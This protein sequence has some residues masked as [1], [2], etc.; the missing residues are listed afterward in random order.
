M[1][2]RGKE[3]VEK[4]KSE[5]QMANVYKDIETR[6]KDRLSTKVSVTAKENGGGKIE[7]EFYSGDDLDRILDI[8]GR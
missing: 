5:S 4:K 1:K 6:M 3:K 2:N 8:I 7:I